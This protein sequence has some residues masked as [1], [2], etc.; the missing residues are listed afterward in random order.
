MGNSFIDAS[1][2][3]F[4]WRQKK[5]NKEVQFKK[6]EALYVFRYHYKMADPENSVQYS[7]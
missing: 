4:G 5:G 7:E 6:G 3:I 1:L 2:I